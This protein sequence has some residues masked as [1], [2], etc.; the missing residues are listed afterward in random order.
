[1]G[2]NL[3]LFGFKFSLADTLPSSAALPRLPGY[4]I[5]YH[6]NQNQKKKTSYHIIPHHN[7]QKL[8]SSEF[9][10][11]LVQMSVCLTGFLGTTA[12]SNGLSFR[13]PRPNKQ[14]QILTLPKQQRSGQADD[15]PPDPPFHV[16]PFSALAPQLVSATPQMTSS[17]FFSPTISLP[18]SV[19]MSMSMPITF[20]PQASPNS[21][22]LTQSAVRRMHDR[23]I[24]KRATPV[25]RALLGMSSQKSRAVKRSRMHLTSLSGIVY[26]SCKPTHTYQPTYL[27]TYIPTCL[28]DAHMRFL[29]SRLP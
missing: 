6:D 4:L 1:M 24:K 12:R 23:R 20:L 11:S 7:V 10:V 18:M 2:G 27:P 15:N 25:T 13:N 29:R 3:V 28:L 17:Y 22:R 8:G 19:S 21:D 26:A 16:N 9:T 5:L 14:D